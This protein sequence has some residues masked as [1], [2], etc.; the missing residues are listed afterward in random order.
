MARYIIRQDHEGDW[1]IYDTLSEAFAT[2][3]ETR[4]ED[5]LALVE[6]H[7]DLAAKIHEIQFAE[8][9]AVI[10]RLEARG[11]TITPPSLTG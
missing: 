6:A 1:N 2:C 8:E 4:S 5:D 7:A 11:Y 9:A 3:Y 10:G